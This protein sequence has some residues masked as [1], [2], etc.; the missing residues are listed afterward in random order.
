MMLS[1]LKRLG[2]ALASLFRRRPRSTGDFLK[3]GGVAAFHMLQNERV[4]RELNLNIEQLGA[5]LRLTRQAQ[6]LRRRQFLA[7]RRQEGNQA[8]AALTRLRWA[9]ASEVLAGLNK[10]AVL[11]EQQKERLRQITW[12]QQ[13]AG[14]FGNP[15]VQE[16]LKLTTGQKEVLR[17]ILEEVANRVRTL[18]SGGGAGKEAVAALRKDAL[19]RALEVLDAEQKARWEQLQGQPFDFGDEAAS[20]DEADAEDAAP[21]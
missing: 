6:Q 9:V 20:P 12:Q 5:V 17:S 2:N 8:V 16:G 10:E 18:H 15:L 21:G 14:A 19:N 7:L 4:R 1:L 3:D 13:G 11:T